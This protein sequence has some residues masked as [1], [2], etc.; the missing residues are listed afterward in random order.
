MAA[1]GMNNNWH[2][3]RV[4]V[5]GLGRFGGGVGVARW[6]VEQGAV[7]T[8]TDLDSAAKLQSSI[9]QLAGSNIKWRLGGHDLEILN[10]C[11][12]LVVNPAV[13]K[14]RSVFFQA[15][16]QRHIPMTTEINLFLQSCPA[17]VIGVTGTV[18]KS[19]TTAMI[20]LAITAVLEH[21]GAMNTC[22]L[23]G[24]IGRSLL[25]D[26]ARIR[27]DD[28]V[29]LEL[30][31]FMLEDLPWIEFSPHIAVVTNLAGNHLDRH[32]TLENYAAAKQNILRFQTRADMAILNDDDSVVRTWGQYTPARVIQYR[33]A[34]RVEITLSVP[35]RHNQSNAY[36]A[37]AVL[38]ALGWGE[39]Q[40][41]AL[42]ALAH[43]P[44]LPHR[45][46]L[47]HTSASGVRWFNDS[48][49]TT[50]EAALTALAAMEKRKCVCI[51]GGY[52]KH[53]D[54]KE[55]CRQL[56]KHAGRVLG[57]GATGNALVVGAIIAGMPP[58]HAF[59]AETLESAVTLAVK[60]I[61]TAAH[62]PRPI[63]AVLLSPAC[64]SYDQFSNYEQRGDNFATLARRY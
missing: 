55:F 45:L 60:W 35:G 7:V 3:K 17:K 50:P 23:G 57:I 38:E 2:G 63:H 64:A 39:H 24:N 4:V 43:F 29:V 25:G 49:A 44:G 32:G 62:S 30:S 51:V 18:G 41:V 56:A 16:R 10:D 48:K 14:I 20:H 9:A 52:D 42:A 27:P 33:A 31:S 8:I 5:M 12:L 19:T 15:A 40:A 6:L 28:L 13:D 21:S 53:A 58:E 46:Q 59:Y 54:M 1:R 11:D 37:L 47:V 22:W 34:G 26:L 36:A 61:T